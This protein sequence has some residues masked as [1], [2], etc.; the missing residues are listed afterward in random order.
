MNKKK[1][2]FLVELEKLKEIDN[3]RKEKLGNI[4]RT[5]M[6]LN[7]LEIYML[8]MKKQ[9]MNHE[10]GSNI[11]L[12]N[13]EQ[14]IQTFTEKKIFV[15]TEEVHLNE[16]INAISNKEIQDFDIIAEKILSMLENWGPSTIEAMASHLPYNKPLMW[17]VLKKLQKA[18]RV[19]VDNGEWRKNVR[20]RSF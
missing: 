14:M 8:F 13:I 19:K 4:S 9:L 3:F 10:N 11:Q 16:D 1:V 12:R 20:T 18:K 17:V 7:G 6:I 15:K 2:H 5:A